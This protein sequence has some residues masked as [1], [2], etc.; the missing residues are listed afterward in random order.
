MNNKEKAVADL[1][2]LHT[3]IVKACGNMPLNIDELA[4]ASKYAAD[5]YNMIKAVE[6]Q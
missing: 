6:K 5:L 4:F 1:K 3:V 2:T